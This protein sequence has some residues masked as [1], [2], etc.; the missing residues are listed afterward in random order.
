MGNPLTLAGATTRSLWRNVL[1]CVV[2]AFAGVLPAWAAGP[3]SAQ[4]TQVKAAYLYKFA[5]YAEWPAGHLAS[6]DSPLVIGIVAAEPLADALEAQARGQTVRG[7]PVKVRR[8]APDGPLGEAHVLYIG[9]TDA[10]SLDTI[11]A[12]LRGKPVLTVSDSRSAQQRGSMIT[13]LMRN[14][15]LRFEV[16]VAPASDNQVRLS[17]LLLTAADRVVRVRK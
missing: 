1:L 17:A 13:F 16:A 2:V 6:P 11:F 8:F 3:E 12:Q 5:S 14:Q 7:H 4:E 10:D 15:R 9:T